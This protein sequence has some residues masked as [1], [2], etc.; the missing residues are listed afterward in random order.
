MFE[1]FRPIIIILANFCK[2]VIIS[3]LYLPIRVLGLKLWLLQF[4]LFVYILYFYVIRYFLEMRASR[5]GQRSILLHA[6]IPLPRRA[7][8]KISTAQPSRARQLLRSEFNCCF[9]LAECV[10]L[11]KIWTSHDHVSCFE[12]LQSLQNLYHQIK[13]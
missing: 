6:S 5:S 4:L 7:L 13:N 8:L 10:H 1:L 3:C 12:Y 2:R 11:C 9:T